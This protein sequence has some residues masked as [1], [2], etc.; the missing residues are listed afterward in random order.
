VFLEV[1]GNS[2]VGEELELLTWTVASRVVQKYQ[3]QVLQSPEEVHCMKYG[4]KTEKIMVC[5]LGLQIIGSLA[6][7]QTIVL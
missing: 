4:Q 7:Y 5:L 3:G 2:W 1:R 6:H